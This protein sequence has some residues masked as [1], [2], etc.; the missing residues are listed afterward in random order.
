MP[1][2]TTNHQ[3]CGKIVQKTSKTAKKA[4]ILKINQN[5]KNS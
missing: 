3:N 1:K 5:F 4:K 2:M